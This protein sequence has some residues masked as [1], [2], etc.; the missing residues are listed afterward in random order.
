MALPYNY[1]NLEG[2]PW[3]TQVALGRVQNVYSIIASGSNPAVGAS[4]EMCW[5]T[6]G[7]EVQH[8]AAEPVVVTSTSIND[9]AGGTGWQSVQLSGLNANFE[10]VSEILPMN[11]TV[12]AVSQNSYI[13]MNR[14]RSVSV[15][16]NGSAF[17]NISV[18]QQTSTE[19]MAI[20]LAG[21]NS[22]N[23]CYFAVPSTH[24]GLVYAC[25]ITPRGTFNMETRL[26]TRGLDAA[27]TSSSAGITGSGNGTLVFETPLLVL[28]STEVYPT[29]LA[30]SGSQ[31]IDGNLQMII[32]PNE[33]VVANHNIFGVEP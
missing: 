20:G 32:V 2:I 6:N 7:I 21:S 1:I 22:C 33:Y 31:V 13:R 10:W 3:L 15:G 16:G 19:L 5:S 4:Q 30:T 29:V 27:T 26:I 28:P 25:R 23:K 12:G 24:Y 17:G 9:T 11:G 18:N 8:A 14:V